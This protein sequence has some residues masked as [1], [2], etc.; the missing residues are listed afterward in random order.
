MSDKRIDNTFMKAMEQIDGLKKVFRQG[1]KLEQAIMES[2]GDV[3]ALAE[4]NR[5]FNDLT[6]AFNKKVSQTLTEGVLDD[7]DDDGFMARSQLYFMAKD[8]IALHGMIDDR[9]DLEPW[10][11]SKIVAASEGMDA[12][13]RY[14]EYRGLQPQQPE[15]EPEMG[16]AVNEDPS[17]PKFPIEVKLAGD[18]MWDDGENPESVM[19]TDYKFDKDEE[20]DISLHVMHDGPWTI[21]TD[22]GFEKAISE[23]IGH[24]VDFSEQGLQRDGVAHLETA[25]DV[26]EGWSELPAIDHEKYQA[27]SGLEGPI[28]TKSGKTVYYDPKE[29]S[30]YD[31]DTDMYMSYDDW[32]A[33]DEDVGVDHDMV[34]DLV[35]YADNDG[36][37]YRQSTAPVQKNLSKKWVKGTYNHDLAIKLWKYHADRAAKKYAQEFGGG[38]ASPAV[39]KAAAKE[40]ADA[41]H[42]E[43]EAGNLHEGKYKNDAQR[44][45][46]HAAKNESVVEAEEKPYIC[47][48]AKKG[49]HECHATSSYGAAKKAAEHW[50]LKSTAGIDAHLAVE[51]TVSEGMEF[52]EKRDGDLQT[53]AKDMFA[54]AKAEAKK[55]MK[56][57][58]S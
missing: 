5:A 2:N 40:F 47:V 45:A 52:D 20:G 19:V 18:S 55:S 11:H 23:I 15:M 14:M 31:P 4:I 24:A 36:D 53:I 6:Q 9:D 21:Y 58:K 35:L 42:A 49:K 34:R 13:R 8:A 57:K 37:L 1:G 26:S 25:D 51:E 38:V 12:V 48:H 3:A 50:K 43:L 10:V 16:E 30:Y 7:T 22:T 28:Q 33:L 17:K 54:H 46:V 32:K 29:G 56:V 27:R 44:K 39:R 41:W